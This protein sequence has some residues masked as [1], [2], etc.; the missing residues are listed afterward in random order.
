MPISAPPDESLEWLFFVVPL[1]LLPVVVVLARL[2]APRAPRWS[3]WTRT[4]G[5]STLGLSTLFL[6]LAGLLQR[7][8]SDN[9]LSMA[10]AASA[11]LGAGCWLVLVNGLALVTRAL[12][13][14]LSGSGLVMGASWSLIMLSTLA[15]SYA[16][17]GLLPTAGISVGLVSVA[18]ISWM[19]THLVWT[20]GLSWW[21]LVQG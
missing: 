8:P 4:V 5:I 6:A 18:L 17:I 1:P 3:G 7:M 16:P 12:P 2:T 9:E 21:L 20:L 14:L 19:L 13:R 15:Y 11:L 10:L